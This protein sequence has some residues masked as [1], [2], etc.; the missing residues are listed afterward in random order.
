[1]SWYNPLTWNVQATEADVLKVAQQVSAAVAV[2]EKDLSVA[3]SWLGTNGPAIIK[4]INTVM[5]IVLELDAGDPRVIAAVAAINLFDAA[6]NAV[7][8]AKASGGNF[9]QALVDAYKAMKDLQ[10]KSAVAAMAVVK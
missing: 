9:A 4:D 6:L 5:I 3:Y 10:S 7:V 8:L 2:A 1:M